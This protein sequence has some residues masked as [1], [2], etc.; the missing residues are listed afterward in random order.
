MVFGRL[1]HLA[2]PPFILHLI[3]SW[4]FP[5]YRKWKARRLKNGFAF[6]YEISRSSSNDDGEIN[7]LHHPPGASKR[8]KKQRATR[9]EAF[10]QPTLT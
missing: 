9:Q 2:A 3:S 1:R 8:K 7:F 10:Y 5:P 4:P 6:H